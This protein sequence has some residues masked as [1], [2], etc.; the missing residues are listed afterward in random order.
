MAASASGS[1]PSSV[2]MAMVRSPSRKRSA[3]TPA[4]GSSAR[5]I[6][7]SSTAQSMVG[8]RNSKAPLGTSAVLGRGKRARR[9]CRSRRRG[10]RMGIGLRGG[11]RVRVVIAVVVGMAM[12]VFAPRMRVRMRVRRAGSERSGSS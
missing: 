6:S 8:M 11:F 2:V 3:L 5:R 4:T 9:G 7:D 1:T 12:V 10:V